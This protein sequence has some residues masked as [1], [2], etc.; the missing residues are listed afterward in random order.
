MTG[1]LERDAEERHEPA[2]HDLLHAL[3][4]ESAG[5][6][7]GLLSVLVGHERKGCTVKRWVLVAALTDFTQ[8]RARPDRSGPERRAHRPR[9]QLRRCTTAESSLH[10]CRAW[11]RH[12]A[13]AP[14][15]AQRS[16]WARSAATA[17]DASAVGRFI[18]ASANDY[19][20]VLVGFC[21]R[22]AAVQ[23]IGP[24]RRRQVQRAS[25][26]SEWCH[27]CCAPSVPRS[28]PTQ[29]RSTLGF[30][31]VG[32]RRRELAVL[33]VVELAVLGADREDIRLLRRLRRPLRRC[34]H[35]RRH[36]LQCPRFRRSSCPRFRRSLCPRFRRSPS[37]RFHRCPCPRYRRS[38]YQLIRRSPRPRRRRRRRNP[39]ALPASPIVT[40][41]KAQNKS[42]RLHGGPSLLGNERG[43]K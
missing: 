42:I 5:G 38:P 24:G 28:Q 10:P 30:V 31:V 27:P 25:D 32:V 29:M 16:T 43:V 41:P 12:D 33:V 40:Q 22:V 13:R 37:R 26:D 36:R 18:V 19:W 8:G 21:R 7:E 39:G 35:R 2:C 20:Q 23:G 14:V 1:G 6:P 3:P 9:R 15:R 11:D 4:A 34:R 17:H